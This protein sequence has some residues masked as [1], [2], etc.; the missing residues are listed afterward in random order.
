MRNLIIIISIAIL[1]HQLGYAQGK[2]P[3]IHSSEKQVS[4][5]DGKYISTR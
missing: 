4:I 2:L 5:R 1:T 3:L